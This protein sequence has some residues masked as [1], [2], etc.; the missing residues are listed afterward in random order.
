[1]SILKRGKKNRA[2]RRRKSTRRGDRINE[3]KL[4]KPLLCLKKSS[5]VSLWMYN[6]SFLVRKSRGILF[7]S[8]EISALIGEL[9]FRDK[10]SWPDPS[11]HVVNFH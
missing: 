4:A 1:M 8:A 5:L 7:I 10:S 6:R 2:L 11:V 9:Y 3:C